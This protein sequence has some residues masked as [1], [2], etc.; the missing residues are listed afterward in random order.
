MA[1]MAALLHDRSAL[2]IVG[3]L[4][5]AAGMAIVLAHQRWSRDLC[6]SW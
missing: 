1:T 6:R 4:G 5:T 3:V 2:I